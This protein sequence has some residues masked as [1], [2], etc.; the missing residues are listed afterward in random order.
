MK[1]LKNF[2]SYDFGRFEDEEDENPI[3]LII[4]MRMKMS[5]KNSLAK[6]MILQMK[7]KMRMKLTNMM[8]MEK[9]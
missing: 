5:T 2:E 8:K 4:K 1:Y 6:M 7:L 3:N 9:K